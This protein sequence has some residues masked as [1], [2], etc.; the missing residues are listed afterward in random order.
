MLQAMNFQTSTANMSKYV[1]L[2]P[3]SLDEIKTQ[4]TSRFAQLKPI[5]EFFDFKRIKKPQSYQE[6]KSNF[7]FNLAYFANNYLL[8]A[9]ILVGYFLITNLFLLISV[10]FAVGGL[11]FIQIQNGNLLKIGQITV[12][13][14]QMWIV[15]GFVCFVLFFFTGVTTSLLWAVFCIGSLIT[16]H[17]SCIQKPIEAEFGDQDM[18]DQI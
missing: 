1:R 5:R 4:V 8:A 2:E 16:L 12:T 14:P 15:Y 7:D 6:A 3:E 18:I 17:A 11:K 13:T 9:V 10:C